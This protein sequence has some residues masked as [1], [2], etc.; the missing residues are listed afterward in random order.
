MALR[1]GSRGLPGGSS[2]RRLL[3]ERFG[4]RNPARLPTL[5][6]REILTWCDAYRRR[7]GRW[8]RPTP[9]PVPESPGDTWRTINQAMRFSRRGVTANLGLREFL[10][11]HRRDAPKWIHRG[12][13][14]ERQIIAWIKDHHRRTGQ[15]PT[16]RSGVVR[17]RPTENW[18]SIDQVLRHGMRGLPGGSTLGFIVEKAGGVALHKRRAKLSNRLLR[19]WIVAHR[20]RTG[21][22]PSRSSGAIADA[23]GETWEGAWAAL[24]AGRRGLQRDEALIG[25]FTRSQ[26]QRWTSQP[27]LSEAQIAAWAVLHHRRSGQWPRAE[28]GRVAD[29]PRESWSALNTSLLRG[30]RG[31]RGGVSLAQFLA[32]RLGVHNRSRQAPLTIP[33]ILAWAKAHHARTGTWPK[34]E[35]GVVHGVTT[36]RWRSI[37]LALRRGLRGL[38]GESSLGALL[39]AKH[40]APHHPHGGPLSETQILTWAQAHFQ[41]TGRWPKSRRDGHVHEA[42]AEHWRRIDNALRIGTRGL[43]RGS[44]LAR[45]LSRHFGVRNLLHPPR[46][47]VKQVLAWADAHYERTGDWPHRQSGPILESQGESWKGIVRALYHGAR[48]LPQ[49]SLV[50]LLAKH[51]GQR[52]RQRGLPLTIERIVLWAMAHHE[53]TGEL[54]A[55]DSGPVHGV[56]GEHWSAIDASLRAGARN[57]RGG[58]SLEQCLRN[59]YEP[60]YADIGHPLTTSLILRWAE[61]FRHR[62]GRWPTRTSAFVHGQGGER[63]SVID[64]ALREGHRGLPGGSSLAKLLTSHRGRAAATSSRAPG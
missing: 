49:T 27:S 21:E 44:S 62:A 48:G 8:P 13:V 42:P 52:Y 39:A 3:A 29:A 9:E 30:S 6:E 24:L 43:R 58:S 41:R 12:P 5:S 54:P 2:L 7:T 36:E 64:Q 23:P 35:S 40:G 4:V 51:R 17:A 25:L 55:R 22:N 63:W 28:S 47:T 34:P 15:W 37:D 50:S 56:P 14:S 11:K 18:V 38:P 59:H 20:Q 33:R 60:P 16:T 32:R 1:N 61:D 57:L 10:V 53:L 26:S 19:R 45:L 31:L 46:L